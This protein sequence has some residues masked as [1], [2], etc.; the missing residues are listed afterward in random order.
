MQ[1]DEFFERVRDTGKLTVLELVIIGL[2]YCLFLNIVYNIFSRTNEVFKAELENVIV[3]DGVKY[4]KVENVF[5][6]NGVKYVRVEHHFKKEGI[7]LK[8]KGSFT[9]DEINHLLDT[10]TKFDAST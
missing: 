8:I 5:V 6:I 7:Y 9:Y 2:I 1:H 3:I 10:M 4:V